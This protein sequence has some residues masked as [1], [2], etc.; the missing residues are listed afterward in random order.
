M[1]REQSPRRS[2]WFKATRQTQYLLVTCPPRSVW[3][4]W[5]SSQRRMRRCGRDL[6]ALCA[7]DWTPRLFWYV[8]V[9]TLEGERLIVELREAQD[10]LRRALSEMGW[11]AVGVQLAVYKDGPALNSPVRMDQVGREVVEPN[12]V[13]ALVA[14]LGL[15]ARYREQIG[16]PPEPPDGMRDA[17][18]VSPSKERRRPRWG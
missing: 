17:V 6:C 12:D 9:L 4:H 8:G 16:G 7:M 15:P 5:D 2:I 11:E 10:D 13:A 3:G 14:Q 1:P 18:P